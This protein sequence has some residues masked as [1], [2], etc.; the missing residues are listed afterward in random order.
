MAEP[1]EMS[2][3]MVDEI[4][5]ILGQEAFPVGVALKP[6]S[7]VDDDP[8]LPVTVPPP[9][10][11]QRYAETVYRGRFGEDDCDIRRRLHR[12]FKLY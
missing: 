10:R 11:L 5:A 9:K 1:K 8:L 3:L 6:V 12:W 2:D 7:S 4:R